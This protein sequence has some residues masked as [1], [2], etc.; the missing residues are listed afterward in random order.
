[1]SLPSDSATS[2][3]WFDWLMHR[4]HAH[5]ADFG[6]RIQMDVAA[7]ADRVLDGAALKQGMT[8]V[9]LGA[10]DGLVGF[11]AIDRIGASLKVIMMDMDASEDVRSSGLHEDRPMY[12]DRPAT[13]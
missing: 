4:R 13:R 12:L 6:Q 10:G 11:R 3:L 1:M 7:Y 8:L 9:D 2:D 5:D